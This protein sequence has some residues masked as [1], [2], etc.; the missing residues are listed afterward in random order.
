MLQCYSVSWWL[1]L[2]EN[3]NLKD[4]TST[5]YFIYVNTNIRLFI[6]A[7]ENSNW[8]A[9]PFIYFK[10]KY[11]RQNIALRASGVDMRG[12]QIPDTNFPIHFPFTHTQCYVK[13]NPCPKVATISLIYTLCFI[14]SCVCN[15][16]LR[17]VVNSWDSVPNAQVG[18]HKTRNSSG[19]RV[20]TY[21]RRG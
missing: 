9:F 12:C 7:T 11:L 19:S 16:S 13:K 6:D 17:R 10:I 3:R 1:G 14:R 20:I 5:R 21:Q 8:M 4:F 15:V 2:R 18:R